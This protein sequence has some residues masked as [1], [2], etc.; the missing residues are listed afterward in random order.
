MNSNKY[1]ELKLHMIKTSIQEL[2]YQCANDLVLNLSKA[3]N[4]PCPL[5]KELYFYANTPLKC[6][7]LTIELLKMIGKKFPLIKSGDLEE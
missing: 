1:V 3:V 4:D 5:E 2:N 6:M 7:I